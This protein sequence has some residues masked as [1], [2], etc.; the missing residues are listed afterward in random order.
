M[1]TAALW[2]LPEP[3]LVPPNN[4]IFSRPFAAYDDP[5]AYPNIAVI[6]FPGA[7]R[8]VIGVIDELETQRSVIDLPALV[9]AWLGF[10]W[11]AGSTGN[12]LLA[13]LGLPS[14]VLVETAFGIA[15]V[16]L[17][18]GL[19]SSSSCPEAIWQ[20]AKWWHDFYAA[21]SP[22]RIAGDLAV[23]FGRYLHRQSEASYHP[24]SG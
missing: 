19:A 18:P 24:P 20:A 9:L 2:P 10:V 8:S 14:A 1:R 16:E 12:P 15:E 13:G 6:R 11:G 17:T 22:G 5:A 21:S 3:S 4:A 7:V 23:P